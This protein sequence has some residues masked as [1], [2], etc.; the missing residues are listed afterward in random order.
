[1]LRI[2]NIGTLDEAYDCDVPHG[3]PDITRRIS[4]SYAWDEGRYIILR[5]VFDLDA[6]YPIKLAAFLPDSSVQFVVGNHT[7]TPEEFQRLIDGNFHGGFSLMDFL[8]ALVRACKGRGFTFVVD[9][10]GKFYI[11]IGYLA[12][13]IRSRTGFIKMVANKTTHTMNEYR[14]RAI[15]TQK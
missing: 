10:Q 15:E 5:V 6:S 13:P 11:T 8:F 1:M 14:K 9:E 4:D 2:R 7:Y 12:E 3:L